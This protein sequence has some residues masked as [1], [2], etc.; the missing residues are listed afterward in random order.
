[1]ALALTSQAVNHTLRTKQL[2][3]SAQASGLYKTGGDTLNL[4][5][6]P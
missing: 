3:L 6:I 5:A 1:M 4:Q 2:Y